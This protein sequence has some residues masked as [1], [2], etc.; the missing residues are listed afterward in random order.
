GARVAPARSR[1]PP[2]ST[3]FPYTTLFRSRSPTARDVGAFSFDGE[4]TCFR[5]LLRNPGRCQ[6]WPSRI[7]ARVSG[8]SGGPSTRRF[9]SDEQDRKSTRLNSSHVKIADAAFCCK[10]KP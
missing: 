7:S 2:S 5:P 10:N 4:F 8:E 1:S 9:Q 6:T 3:R